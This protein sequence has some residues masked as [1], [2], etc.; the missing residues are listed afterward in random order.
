MIEQSLDPGNIIILL[1]FRE[2]T[3]FPQV[4][5]MINLPDCLF[6]NYVF[7]VTLKGSRDLY[8]V[9]FFFLA[10]SNLYWGGYFIRFL[11]FNLYQPGL[12]QC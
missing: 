6:E 4:D 2:S 8:L 1:R 5:F 7:H 3:F 9:N 10:Q 11:S 12:L